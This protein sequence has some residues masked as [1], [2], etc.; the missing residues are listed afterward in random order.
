MPLN[1][2]NSYKDMKKL[3]LLMVGLV[4]AVGANAYTCVRFKAGDPSVLLKKSTA[5]LEINYDECRVTNWDNVSFNEYLAKRG[6]DFV[7]DWPEDNVK[8]RAYFVLRFNRASDYLTIVEGNSSTEYKMIVRIKSLD[9]GNGGSAFN[10]WAS[11]KAGGMIINGDIEIR[12]ATDN[13][14]L[15]ILSIINGQG[16]GTA[17][18]TVRLGLALSEVAGDMCDFIED[19]VEDGNIQATAVNDSYANQMSGR[20]QVAATAVPAA[21][22]KASKAPGEQEAKVILKNGSVI[23]G[24]LKAFNPVKEITIVV[25]GIA[26]TIPMSEVDHIETNEADDAPAQTQPATVAQPVV[27]PTPA[28]AANEYLGS[29][30][31]LVTDRDNYPESF[32]IDIN[33]EKVHMLLVRGGRMNMGYNGNGSRSMMSEPVHEV[34]VTSFY[35]SE[36]PLSYNLARS[37]T[38]RDVKE[39]SED[40]GLAMVT[41]YDRVEEIVKAIAQQ[42]GKPYRLP[43][44]AEWEYAVSCELQN[45]FFDMMD[46]YDHIAYEWCGDFHDDFHTGGVVTD[47]TGPTDGHEHVIRAINADGSKYN[48][49]NKVRF[50][51]CDLG[52]V[53]LV[54]K[55]KD[56]K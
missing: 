56:V 37:I 47:P 55:A 10:P 25:A 32:D 46:K 27:A 13:K 23:I 53:R 8:T 50:G 4:V 11:A 5:S 38:R 18:E 19:D 20:T 43:T 2:F 15:C 31:L 21:A 34:A 40:D 17:S 42:A 33:G 44:E 39:S 54:I 6:D 36:R 26:T 45:T 28:P 30:K 3:L 12:N 52:F 35:M 7:R 41:D 49:S 22:P 24:K 48:R 1:V 9:V 14:L 16:L 51:Q 29:R